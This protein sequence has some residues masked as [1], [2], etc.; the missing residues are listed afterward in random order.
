M[1]RRL[2]G[3]WSKFG[4]NDTVVVLLGSCKSKVQNNRLNIGSMTV[5]K[6]G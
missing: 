4:G 2:L 1:P 5:E 3:R 6:V